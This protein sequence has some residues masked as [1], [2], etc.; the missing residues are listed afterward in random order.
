MMIVRH[1]K[2]NLADGDEED[3]L[4]SCIYSFNIVY[5]RISWH[6][7]LLPTLITLPMIRLLMLSLSNRYDC[8]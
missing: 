5:T 4:E 8:C 6:V 1:Q 2:S 7:M 3:R